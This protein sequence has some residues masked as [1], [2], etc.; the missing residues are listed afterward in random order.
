M[1]T[2]H[3]LSLS[4]SLPLFP[5]LTPHFIFFVYV[6][7]QKLV[8]AQIVIYASEDRREAKAGTTPTTTG[9]DYSKL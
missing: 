9:N 5:S 7:E 6:A 8:K 2:G 1:T 3:S 4:L